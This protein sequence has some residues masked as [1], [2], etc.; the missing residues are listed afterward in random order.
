MCEGKYCFVEPFLQGAYDIRIQRVGDVVRA[1][2]RQSVSGNWKTN[3]GSSMIEAIEVTEEYQRWADIAATMFGGLDILSVDAIHD[4]TTGKEYI[5]EVNDTSSGLAPDFED[6]DNQSIRD[7]IVARLNEA[8][9]IEAGPRIGL[10]PF[11][12]ASGSAQASAG[13][14]TTAAAAGA[15]P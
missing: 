5:L 14:D 9:A 10:S 11:T 13:D 12:A 6:E 7:L 1:F 2:K 8:E 15:P 4:G 3:T